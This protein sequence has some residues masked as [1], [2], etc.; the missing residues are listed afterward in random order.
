M[1]KTKINFSGRSAIFSGTAGV[2]L[3]ILALGSITTSGIHALP[4]VQDVAGDWF[5]FFNAPGL[6]PG[7]CRLTIQFQQNRSFSGPLDIE[8]PP[9]PCNVMI[10]GAVS[11]SNNVS[12]TGHNDTTG[13]RASAHV[14]FSDF[15]D[16][17][18]LFDGDL[19]LTLG[20]GTQPKG[21]VVQLRAF[22]PDPNMPP[23][24]MIGDYQ[25][26]GTSDVNGQQ[27]PIIIHIARIVCDC[28]DR[29]PATVFAAN[30]GI[31]TA[32]FSAGYA[33]VSPHGEQTT[34]DSEPV[35]AYELLVIGQGNDAN[36]RIMG[37]FHVHAG[38]SPCIRGQFQI[39]N[40][41][42]TEDH[43]QFEAF[44]Q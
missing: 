39:R 10:S 33:T 32:M 42:G 7:P 23:P 21:S 8:L 38:V 15:G 34:H 2:G 29:P 44:Q 43:G 37:A 12:F 18:A 25:G 4:A 17:G 31:S 35:V 19:K 22:M 26:N 3:L 40:L 5:G 20:D 16:G 11:A 27:I 24:D 14:M 9:D 36:A 6:P 1:N 30:L 28:I 13:C 41:D